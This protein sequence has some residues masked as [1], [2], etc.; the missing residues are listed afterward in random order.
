MKM[1]KKKYLFYCF[2]DI[3]EISE[4]EKYEK[5]IRDNLDKYLV[6]YK[7]IISYWKKKIKK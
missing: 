6:E 1:K 4:D 2:S 5:K 7:K 3:L